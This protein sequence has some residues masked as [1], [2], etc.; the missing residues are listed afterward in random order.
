MSALQNY[1]HNSSDVVDNGTNDDDRHIIYQVFTY[2]KLN[3]FNEL[4]LILKI[5]LQGK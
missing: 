5:A 2:Y 1:L 3:I 4:A